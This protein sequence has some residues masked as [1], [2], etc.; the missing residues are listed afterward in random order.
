M[1]AFLTMLLGRLPI[2]WLQLTHNPARFAAALAGVAFADILIFMQL[3]FLGALTESTQLPY[4][5]LTADIIISASDAHTLSD[6]SNIPRQRLYQALSVPGVASATPVYIGKYDWQAGL[7]TTI[8][9]QIFGIDPSKRIFAPTPKM[10]QVDAN[11][12]RLTLLDTVLIDRKTRNLSPAILAKLETDPSYTFEI[13]GRT[14]TP[15]GSFEMGGGFEADGYLI[16]SD[17]TFLQLFPHRTA[18]APTHIF[19]KVDK[20]ADPAQVASAIRLAVPAKDIIV[21]TTQDAA[22]ADSTY[23]T[24]EKPI[25]VIFGFGTIMGLLIGLIIVYQVL[26]TDVADHL[27]EYATL[28]A[29]GYKQS[30]FLSIIF[31]EATILAL[32]GFIP[33]ICIS[34]LL[35]SAVADATGLPVFMTTARPFAVFFGTAFMCIASGAIATRRLASADPADLF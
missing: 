6:G 7:D 32:L 21:R 10:Q 9:F 28:K 19:L 18:G 15:I 20:N 23:Q 8:N 25:G 31:E 4:R 16:V 30:F 11:R 1:T 12:A 14:L 24:T 29:I 3:G 27:G 35:Y 34:L 17:Q 33:G 2:G 26:S 22:A 5:P 13:N